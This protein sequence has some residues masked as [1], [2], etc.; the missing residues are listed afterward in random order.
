MSASDQVM[1]RILGNVCALLYLLQEIR[2]DLEMKEVM[3]S[4]S[5]ELEETVAR[6]LKA[7]RPS[8]SK[9]ALIT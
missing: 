2:T 5:P 6:V 9:N 4:E 3:D 8:Q 1:Q 7:E